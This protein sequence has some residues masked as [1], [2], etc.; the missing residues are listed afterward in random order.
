MKPLNFKILSVGPEA[1]GASSAANPV[2][3]V[4]REAHSS[5]NKNMYTSVLCGFAA[6]V[7]FTVT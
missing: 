3:A 5:Q 4:D 6:T 7:A 2:D 1:K